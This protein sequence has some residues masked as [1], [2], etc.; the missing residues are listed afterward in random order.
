VTYLCTLHVLGEEGEEQLT[1]ET[2]ENA[3]FVGVDIQDATTALARADL[4]EV[5]R[6]AL[7]AVEEPI[8]VS[9]HIRHV[10]AAH[11]YMRECKAKVSCFTS[12]CGVSCCSL[13]PGTVLAGLLGQRSHGSVSGTPQPHTPGAVFS[14]SLGHWFSNAHNEHRD[15]EERSGKEEGVKES[16][17]SLPMR[18]TQRDD[19][20]KPK[21]T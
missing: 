12:Q 2:I 4:P 14:G 6:A 11:A 10:A 9:V 5:I 3:I 20:Q 21:K 18:P 17:P 1:V 16:V 13:V 15:V 7:L 8:T 19:C